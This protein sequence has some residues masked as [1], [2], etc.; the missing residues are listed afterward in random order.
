[1]TSLEIAE[2]FDGT[3]VQDHEIATFSFTDGTTDF[4]CTKCC[5]IGELVN[6]EVIYEEDCK[7]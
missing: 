6:N 4:A 1:M 7:E 3:T 2:A 5:E